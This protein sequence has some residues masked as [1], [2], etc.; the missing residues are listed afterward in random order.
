[1]SNKPKRPGTAK[2]SAPADAPGPVFAEPKNA[3]AA[4]AA[5]G[6]E[7]A[8]DLVR[9]MSSV[10]H[11]VLA[12]TLTPATANAA[13]RAGAIMIGAAALQLRYG[14]TNTDGSRVLHLCNGT[15]GQKSD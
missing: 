15:G 4:I 8:G 11:G 1:M 7:T 6:V 3:A 12:G 14:Q 10:L 13:S 2:G 9:V 5:E